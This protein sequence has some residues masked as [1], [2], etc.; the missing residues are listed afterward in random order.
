M[1]RSA[2][3]LIAVSAALLLASA[4]AEDETPVPE[5]D[6]AR[7]IQPLLSDRCFTCHGPDEESRKGDLRLDREDD[8]FGDRGGYFVVDRESP[9]DSE[10]LIRVLS[11]FRS[12]VMPPPKA[13]KSLEADEIELLRRWVEAGAP[14]SEHWAF[15]APTRPALPDVQ[16]EGRVRNEIDRFVL[17][18][19]ESQGLRFADEADPATLIRRVSLD[20]TGL[21]PSPIEVRAFVADPSE[22][23]YLALVDRLLAS[24]HYGE[25][26]ALRWLDLARYADTNGYSIDG[27]RHM[28]AWRDWVIDA[29]NGNLPYDEFAVEQLAGD[30]LPEATTGQRIASGFNR[31]HMITHEGGTILEEYRTAYVVDRVRTTSQ[32]FLGL[33]VGCAQC[34]DHKYDPISQREYYELFAYFN[35][36]TDRGNDG[37]GGVNS[38]PYIPVL[39]YEQEQE[40]LALEAQVEERT[41]ALLA[42]DAKLDA[43]QREWEIAERT[44][45]AE[46]VPPTLG[47]WHQI[48]P[49]RAPSG[50]EAFTTAFEPEAEIDLEASYDDGQ[51]QWQVPT[52]LEDGTAYQLNGGNS[53][54]YFHRRIDSE[55]D[56]A[57]ELSLGSDDAIRLWVNGELL[58]DENVQ[59]GVAADQEIVSAPLR[60]GAND[61]LVKIVNYG[62]P[63][64]FY[65]DLKRAGPPDEISAI[66]TTP[67]EARTDEAQREL[68]QYFRST[69]SAL[70]DLRAEIADLEDRVM[71]IEAE[72]MTTAM[73]MEEMSEPRMTY[74]L[75]RGAYDQRGE[76]V[77]PGTPSCLPPLPADAPP[78]RLGF[79]QWLVDPEHPLT[80]R[81]AVNGFWAQVFG[82]GLV[83]TSEDFGTRGELP[84]HPQLL[85]WLAVEFVESG[86][87]VKATMRRLVTSSAYR[88]DAA[89][90]AELLELD[91]ENRLYARGPSFRL[92]AELIRDVALAAS[93]LLVDDV[94]GPSVRPYQPDGLWREMSHFGSTPATEQVYVQ[95]SGEKLHRRGLY[96]VLKR[97]VPPPTLAAFD[98]P[99]RELCTTRR[100]RTNTPIQALVLMNE[101]GFVEAARAM[102]ERVMKEGGSSVDERLAYAFLLAVSREPNEA[103]LAVVRETYERELA[104]FEADP[105][106]A[107]ALLSVGEAARDETLDPAQHA[108]FAYVAHL[109]LNL[110]E[111]ITRP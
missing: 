10:L 61:V 70:A 93:G 51:L 15:V 106:A 43:A 3:A 28:W 91:P 23:A 30:L 47:E 102:A 53:A 86:W 90:S 31:N 32:A 34:H 105:D 48:G 21:P 66:V 1:V 8:V 63:G 14:W 77:S 38:V 54:W 4:G 62:G 24:P 9:E 80:A 92:P 101:T 12:E 75:E 22:E 2:L 72:A 88:Q 25:R 46:R 69:T 81:V 99:N 16:D 52:E 19:L 64:G 103:E 87:D 55:Q 57:V 65:F 84:S 108:A 60:A 74:V 96:T 76:Q 45:D 68:L 56:D 110:S 85:D 5:V 18:H 104:A 44:R 35:T 39:S 20:L 36:I 7:Q 73:V 33:T 50:D 27:G 95:D 107:L 42:P 71:T 67:R 41:A 83:K 59:R 78:N 111:T 79:A 98:A 94:G 29:F 13:A 26:M 82:T 37:N 49:F 89:V 11:E 6:F 58:V 40:R 100:A 97:T 109:V 17:A